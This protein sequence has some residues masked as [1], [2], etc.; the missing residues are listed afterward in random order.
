MEI[1]D[2]PSYKPPS[3]LGM[4]TMAMLNNQMVSHETIQQ[5]VDR[6][7]TVY[8]IESIYGWSIS[9]IMVDNG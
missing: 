1:D 7:C 6:L 9:G 3:L 2:F 8:Q 5:S 4:N